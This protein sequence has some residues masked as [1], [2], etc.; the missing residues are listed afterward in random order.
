MA[1]EPCRRSNEEELTLKTTKVKLVDGVEKQSNHMEELT[2][3]VLRIYISV[4]YNVTGTRIANQSW[5]SK[6]SAKGSRKSQA[7]KEQRPS[8]ETNKITCCPGCGILQLTKTA[9]G[10]RYYL[11]MIDDRSLII[12]DRATV[13]WLFPH[14]D[15]PSDVAGTILVFK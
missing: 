11:I 4:E 5:R 9:G 12:D 10:C 2:E 7:R 15:P 6:I 14:M 3:Q 13:K 1:L 8:V